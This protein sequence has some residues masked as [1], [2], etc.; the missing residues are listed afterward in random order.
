MAQGISGNPSNLPGIVTD[1]PEIYESEPALSDDTGVNDLDLN[2][3]RDDA[4]TLIEV[5]TRQAFAYFAERENEIAQFYV[6]KHGEY[7][8]SSGQVDDET[9]IEK[10]HRLTSEVNQLL[11]KFQADKDRRTDDESMSI[12]TTKLTGNLEMLSR[13]LKALEVAAD[14]GSLNPAQ[15]CYNEIKSRLNQLKDKV[16]EADDDSVIQPSAI[17]SSALER[18]LK[19]LEILV[20]G[21]DETIQSILEN[22]RCDNLVDAVDTLSAWL[23]SF[24]QDNVQRVNSELD[25]L[26]QR[27]DHMKNQAEKLDADSKSKLDQL[28]NLVTSRDKQEAMVTTIIHRLKSMEELQRGASEVANTVKQME[29]IQSQIEEKL[30]SNEGQLTALAEMFSKN[31]DLMKQVSSDI[32]ARISAMTQ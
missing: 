25:Y 21:N 22:T 13:Q 29:Q 30:Q 15:A 24:Q 4:I 18:R 9:D 8:L 10:Y 17:R 5:P 16:S 3:Q 31:I 20:G 27:L 11:S 1:Q 32:D 19:T 28:F 23:G 6:Q 12:R 2:D 14:D 26:T 7:K